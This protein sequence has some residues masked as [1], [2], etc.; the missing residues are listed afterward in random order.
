MFADKGLT[1]IP[2]KADVNQRLKDRMR[3]LD[4]L[5]ARS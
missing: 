5:W 3:W 1:K 2:V 4:E